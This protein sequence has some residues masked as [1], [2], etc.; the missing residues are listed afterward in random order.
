MKKLL[1]CLLAAAGLAVSAYSESALFSSEAVWK[2]AFGDDMT[3]CEPSFSDTDWTQIT[4]PGSINMEGDGW[5]WMRREITVPAE[6]AGQ[7]VFLNLGQANGAFDVY[8]DGSYIGSFGTLPPETN[9]R[10]LLN[11]MI[12]IP[13]SCIHDGKVL[14]AYRVWTPATV[15]A[16]TA[17]PETGSKDR[18]ATINYLKN[19]INLRLYV[20]L[21]ALCLFISFYAFSSSSATEKKNHSLCMRCRCCLF[22]SIFMTWVQNTAC[23]RILSSV[24]WPGAVCP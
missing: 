19:I 23:C 22:L 17:V 14:V 6:L 15:F 9:I 16:F 1:I 12:P 10:P 5:L 20:I 8:A 21:A 13:A 18:A 3:R 2:Y 11:K 24:P 4:E 7:P